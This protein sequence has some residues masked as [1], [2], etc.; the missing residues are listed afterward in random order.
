V[1]FELYCQLL[2]QSVSRLKGEP[3][4]THIRASVNLDFVSLGEGGRD[5]RAR[6]TD[7]GF[8][9]LREAEIAGSR[10][11]MLEAYVPHDYVKETRLRIDFYRR[12]ALAE[13]TPEVEAIA[14]EL[15]DRFGKP[16]PSV[17]V[18]LAV[19]RIR[20]QA[21]AAGIVSVSNEGNRLQC[22]RAS[23]KA[24]D[25]VKLGARF[26]RLTA[27]KPLPRLREIE[28]FLRRNTPQSE[29]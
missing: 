24:Q 15:A 26:P 4:S 1:G 5:E 2:R 8:G 11:D 19:T 14:Q 16:P 9:A 18:L 20:T 21:E 28:Q 6:S 7:F 17:E 12:L 29:T 27:E 3:V 13:T 23:G 22:L 10:A 25:F